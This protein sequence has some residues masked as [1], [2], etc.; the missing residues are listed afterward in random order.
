MIVS[1]FQH[2]LLVAPI[3]LTGFTALSVDTNT[4][5]S[6]KY[7]SDSFTI[8]NVPPR[9]VLLQSKDGILE[10][11]RV[12]RQLHGKQYVDDF[13]KTLYHIHF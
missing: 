13:R 12:C 1:I 9:L 2:A 4:N 5:L 10:L 8:F 3:T 11:E 6:T 7:L